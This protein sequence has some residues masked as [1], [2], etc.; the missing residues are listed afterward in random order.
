MDELVYLKRSLNLF[1]EYLNLRKSYLKLNKK[2]LLSLWDDL[3]VIEREILSE[4]ELYNLYFKYFNKYL[5][6]S[7]KGNKLKSKLEGRNFAEFEI[8]RFDK[9][10][11]LIDL[12][13]K[14]LILGV[15]E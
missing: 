10:G 9:E 1:N 3:N 15:I 11:N 13:L 5:R 2:S 14:Y 6:R 8:K 4:R 7:K 12:V